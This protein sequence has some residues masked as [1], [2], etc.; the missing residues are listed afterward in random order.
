MPRRRAIRELGLDAVRLLDPIPAQE[1][2]ALLTS[3]DLLV[4][5]YL[6]SARTIPGMIGSKFYEYCAAG[7]PVLV[8]GTGMGADLVRRIGN[9]WTCEAGNP[10]ELARVLAEFLAS[11][12]DARARGA[13]GRR[14]AEQHFDKTSR[15][16]RWERILYEAAAGRERRA[17][18]SRATIQRSE[19]AL[20]S[21]PPCAILRRVVRHRTASR[22]CVPARE[23]CSTSI[24]VDGG[25]GALRKI[26]ERSASTRRLEEA[27]ATAARWTRMIQVVEILADAEQ[28][29]RLEARYRAEPAAFAL[30]LQ[31]ACAERPDSLVL[32]VWRQRL[33]DSAPEGARRPETPALPFVVGLCMALGLLVKL[34]DYGPIPWAWWYPRFAVS[35]V[36][37][38]LIA[39]FLQ[40]PGSRPIRAWVLGSAALAFGYTALLPPGVAASDDADGYA[41][42]VAMALI[43]LPLLT[44]SLAAVSFLGHEWRSLERRM[45]FLRHPSASWSSSARSSFWAGWC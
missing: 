6:R 41:D 8:H 1:V 11:P 25:G 45:G 44:L 2:P 20:R 37:L 36:V 17:V 18:T 27:P 43:H 28:P 33:F 10:D 30:A 35:L 32:Q 21:R 9:G 16:E 29:D 5:S 4:M 19:S 34:P 31:G 42:S 23:A 7:R 26:V 15:H 38:A 14:H 12:S 22:R 39:Y 40:K 24:P 3:C 13:L